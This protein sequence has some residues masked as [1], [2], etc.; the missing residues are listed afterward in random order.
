MNYLKNMELISDLQDRVQITNAGA[1]IA[2]YMFNLVMGADLRMPELSW[3][4]HS[5]RGTN[6]SAVT[7]GRVPS[8][9]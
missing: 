5:A 3:R 2:Q 4:A 7:L 6:M 8:L 1:T 9:A